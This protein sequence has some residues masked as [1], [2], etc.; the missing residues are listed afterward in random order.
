MAPSRFFSASSFI[1][2]TAP[3]LNRN[4]SS[5]CAASGD[6]P[7]VGFNDLL[8]DFALGLKSGCLAHTCHYAADRELKTRAGLSELELDKTMQNCRATTGP[9]GTTTREKRSPAGAHPMCRG[10]GRRTGGGPPVLRDDDRGAEEVR[11][12]RPGGRYNRRLPPRVRNGTITDCL[13][14]CGAERTKRVNR[15]DASAGQRCRAP[16]PG[17]G[18]GWSTEPFALLVSA[19]SDVTRILSAIE[20]GDPQ[21]A[22]QLLP[23]V[24]DELRR[25]AAQTLAKEKPRA[26]PPGHG[27]GPR[28]VRPFARWRARPELEQSGAFLLRRGR[29]HAP[30]PD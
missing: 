7:A 4:R 8:K 10:A 1:R 27:P 2:A 13:L 16:I 26:N 19:M 28:G 30:H 25:L 24:Y 3:V 12:L 15:R 18:R 29:G 9:R 5:A 6:I 11:H 17:I 20:Q 21:A 23:L 14:E 22:E